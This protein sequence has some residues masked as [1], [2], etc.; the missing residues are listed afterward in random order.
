MNNHAFDMALEEALAARVA[1]DHVKALRIAGELMVMRPNNFRVRKVLVEAAACLGMAERI[2]PVLENAGERAGELLDCAVILAGRGGHLEA[3]YQIHQYGEEIGETNF[4]ST[5]ALAQIALERRY[6]EVVQKLLARC[7]LH[8]DERK[9]LR[10][11]VL[12]SQAR[13]RD[14]IGLLQSIDATTPHRETSLN[15]LL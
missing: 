6:P 11:E 13:Y 15:P 2:A 7:K 14:A 8:S 10:S 9:I 1:S 5:L 12:L 4:A 3:A